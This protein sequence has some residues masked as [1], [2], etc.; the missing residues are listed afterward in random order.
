MNSYWIVIKIIF[1]VK[2]IFRQFGLKKLIDKSQFSIFV[3]NFV[4]LCIL[5]DIWVSQT[6]QHVIEFK[7]QNTCNIYTVLQQIKILRFQT[8]IQLPGTNTLLPPS[9]SNIDLCKMFDFFIQYFFKTF[10][11][12]CIFE[13]K[14]LTSSVRLPIKEERGFGPEFKEQWAC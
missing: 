8:K 1:S 2:F 14:W 11:I 4:S 6:T 3:C 9:S 13:R 10:L 12:V 7:N 5:F